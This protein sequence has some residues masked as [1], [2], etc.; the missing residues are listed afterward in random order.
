ML[1]DAQW[2]RLSLRMLAIHPVREVARYLPLLIAIVFVGHSAGG[3]EHWWGLGAMVAAVLL[4][5]ARWYTTT[6]RFTDDQVQLRRGLVNATTVTAPIDRVRS[7]DVTAPALHRLLGLAEVRIGTGAGEKALKLDGLTTAEAA[8]LR[9]ELLHRARADRDTVADASQRAG[10]RADADVA[11]GADRAADAGVTVARGSGTSGDAAAAYSTDEFAEHL[12]Y[13]LNPR[14]IRFAPFGPAGLLAALAVVAVGSQLFRDTGF[15]PATST[16]VR[17][18]ASDVASHGTTVAVASAA[19]L[20]LGVV[21]VLSLVAYLLAFHGF[22]LTRDDVGGTLHVSRGLVTTRA[23]SLATNRLR[24]VEEHRPIP[25][26]W[27]GGA[28]LDAITTGVKDDGKAMSSTLTPPSPARV[29]RQTGELVLRAPGVLDLPLQQHGPAATRRR[30]TRVFGG[31]LVLV[32]AIVAVPLAGDAPWAFVALAAVPL[33]VA[34]FL[35]RSRAHWLGH[36]VTERFLITR[37]GS[38]TMSTNV[39]ELSGAVG[40]TVRRSFFQRRAGVATVSLATAAG[41]KE[42]AVLDAPA[43]EVAQLA[44]KILPG[45]VEQFL[46]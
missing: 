9:G 38:I 7:V 17:N 8:A 23:T 6:Y 18:T 11:A 29:V 30:Y 46:R 33:L 5:L 16:T 26:R 25:L 13:Q 28:R 10:Q 19:V 32:A 44:G 12:L 24:G 20:L 4:G 35:G 2:R 34:P 37:A 36:A 14:W 39:I 41:D 45:H 43:A 42:Y 15:N 21:V 31:A 3:G 40:V 27:V 1:Q 22:R